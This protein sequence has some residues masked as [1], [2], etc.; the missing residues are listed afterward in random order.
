MNRA[1]KPMQ[2]LLLLRHLAT[3][4]PH[5]LQTR[6]AQAALARLEARGNE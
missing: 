6:E 4:S 2:S 1:S 3:G 5:A